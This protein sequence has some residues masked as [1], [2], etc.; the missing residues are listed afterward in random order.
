VCDTR[1]LNSALYEAPQAA[2]NQFRNE[3]TLPVTRQRVRIDVLDLGE[4]RTFVAW[5]RYLYAPSRGRGV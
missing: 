4:D 1:H 5:Y 2:G 3:E